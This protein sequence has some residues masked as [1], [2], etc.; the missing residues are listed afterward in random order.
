MK[1][2]NIEV[3]FDFLDADD[4]EK[5]E[6]EAKKVVKQ[7]E[8]KEKQ[9]MSY[10]QMIRE[11]CKIINDFFNNVFGDGMSEKLFGNKDNLKEHISAFEEIVK[12]KENQ[13]KSIVSSL[14]RYQPNR[15]TRRNKRK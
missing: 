5:F 8:E 9:Q 3:E 11:Q 4:M 15:E 6:E 2:R 7:C 12:E 10:S 14:E 13:Q 1:I